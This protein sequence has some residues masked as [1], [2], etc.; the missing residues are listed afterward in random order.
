MQKLT[1][2]YLMLI[3]VLFTVVGLAVTFEPTFVAR[4]LEMTV[5][6]ASAVSDFRAVYG[7]LCFA[8][9]VLGVMAVRREELRHTVVL[10]FV[11]V[12]DGLVLGRLIS[13]ATHGPGS[14]L[15]NAQ[16]VLELV[17]AVA[18]FVVL[19]AMSPRQLVHA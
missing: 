7:G 10:A 17:G 14:V 8:V 9:A 16:L 1:V 2:P 13:W 5:E 3:T 12:C 18:G 4:Q 15:I 6:S 19:R 11:L